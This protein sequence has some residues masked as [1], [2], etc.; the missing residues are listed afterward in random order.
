VP[1]LLGHRLADHEP[2]EPA[3]LDLRV[4]E[5][6][7]LVEHDVRVRH[8]PAHG[9]AARA[10]RRRQRLELRRVHDRAV[11]PPAPEVAPHVLLADLVPHRAAPRLPRKRDEPRL[12][13]HDCGAARARGRRRV[14]GR[15][16]TQSRATATPPRVVASPGD[17]PQAAP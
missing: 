12:H 17:L 4:L 7:H 14:R 6:V 16:Q 1:D 10:R 5:D 2:V 13:V 11:Q 8:D 3:A 9:G 15:A